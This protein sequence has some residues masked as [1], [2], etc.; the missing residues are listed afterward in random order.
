MGQGAVPTISGE[1]LTPSSPG[2]RAALLIGEIVSQRRAHPEAGA[3][4]TAPEQG[5]GVSSTTHKPAKQ[6]MG[7]RTSQANSRHPHTGLRLYALGLRLQRR[8]QKASCPLRP[9][10][11]RA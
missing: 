7:S 8:Q 11:R 6:Q 2:R 9:P 10:R 5:L 3:V 1:S 4:L